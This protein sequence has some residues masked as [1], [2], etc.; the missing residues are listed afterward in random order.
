MRPRNAVKELAESRRMLEELLRIDVAMP[1]GLD[2]EYF[3]RVIGEAEA[4]LAAVNAA[5]D[6]LAAAV[7]RKNRGYAVMAEL[8]K[9][10][11]A[12]IKGIFGDD[13]LEYE[14]FGGKRLSR[15]KRP[16]R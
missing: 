10:L 5:V 8:R 4:A 7:D 14:R 9:R 12:A 15:R 6:L 2:A 3:S 16:S 1:A 11:R 13:S